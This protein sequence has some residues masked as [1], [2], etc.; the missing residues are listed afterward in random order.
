[1]FIIYAICFSIPQYAQI[2]SDFILAN[3]G[4]SNQFHI[5][6]D[7]QGRLYATWGSDGVY[8]G[9][10]DSLG[11]PFFPTQ[12]VKTTNYTTGNPRLALNK[13]NIPIVWNEVV[14]SFNRFVFGRTLTNNGVPISEEFVVNDPFYDS[15][16]NWT[17]V[18]FL[19]DSTFIVVWSG[20]GLSSPFTSNNSVWGQR[21]TTSLKYIGENIQISEHVMNSPAHGNSRVLKLNESGDFV[22]IWQDKHSGSRKVYGRLFYSDGTPQDSSF[23]ISED[24]QIT[25]VWSISAVTN[26]GNNFAV[27]WSAE[28]DTLW[29]IYWRRFKTNSTPLSSAKKIN[30]SPGVGTKYPCVDIAIGDRGNYII[31]WEQKYNGYLKIFGQKFYSDSVALGVNFRISTFPDSFSHGFPNVTI[32]N[33]KILTAWRANRAIWANVIKYSNSPVGIEHDY[34]TDIT[35]PIKLF[36]NYPNPFNASTIIKFNVSEA[37]IVKLDIYNLLGEMIVNLQNELALPGEYQVLWDGKDSK[38]QVVPSGIYF[39]RLKTSGFSQ[40]RKLLFVQ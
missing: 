40:I 29:Q 23:L 18:T 17:D 8:F 5:K 36:Q 21:L 32:L 15:V 22:V 1:M 10:Y 30:T 35:Q 28:I 19:N 34:Y 31:V 7:D 13:T 39:Y 25:D 20:E 24:S 37:S 11:N 33:N 9:V 12:I 4:S 6:Y 3:E 16:R 26:D 27:V 38:R 2:R 14:Q